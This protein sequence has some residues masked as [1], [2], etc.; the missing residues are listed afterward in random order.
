MNC[1]PNALAQAARCFSC[2]DDLASIE[3]Y[4]L[5]RW[6]NQARP[7]DVETPVLTT[8]T[9]IDFDTGT[10]QITW[11]S[12]TNPTIKFKIYFGQTSGGPYN[13]PQSP[14]SV[15]PNLRT[16]IITGLGQNNTYSFVVTA[17][18][19]LVPLCESSFSNQ[20]QVDIVP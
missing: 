13:D 16:V 15:A 9:L 8:A 18:D 14:V 2:P 10:V 5:C 19:S 20:I 4:L 1:D 11:T 12:T 3:T 7:C 6:L 17:V